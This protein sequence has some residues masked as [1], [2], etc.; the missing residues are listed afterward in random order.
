MPAHLFA[1][2]DSSSSAHPF[3]PSHTHNTSLNQPHP[4]PT[5]HT[6]THAHNRDAALSALAKQKDGQA[7]MRAEM[8][9]LLGNLKAAGWVRL[10]VFYDKKQ[11]GRR[12]GEGGCLLGFY[13]RKQGGRR[14]GEWGCLF[15]CLG[16]VG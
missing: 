2:T 5:T 4:Q 9:A 13:N 6:H 3:L 15:V 16:W 14:R 10:L 12:K 8:E 11:G 7:G 1:R